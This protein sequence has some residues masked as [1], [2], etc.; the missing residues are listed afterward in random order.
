MSAHSGGMTTDFI[1]DE[2]RGSLMLTDDKHSF[3]HLREI[4]PNA[5]KVGMV[6]MD[7]EGDVGRVVDIT[8]GE[9]EGLVV[10]VEYPVDKTDYVNPFGWKIKRPGVKLEAIA[11]HTI[12]ELY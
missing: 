1:Y 5:F 9:R 6:I 4:P 3:N 10:W 2:V 7:N 8:D 11:G 12:E